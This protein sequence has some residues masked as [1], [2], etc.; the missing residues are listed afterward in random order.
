MTAHHSAYSLGKLNDS[1]ASHA[2]LP[3][4]GQEAL[5]R[6]LEQL[7]QAVCGPDQ[8]AHAFCAKL[9]LGRWLVKH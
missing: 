7:P 9:E 1:Q 5:L 3:H 2:L 6:V 8:A 4:I